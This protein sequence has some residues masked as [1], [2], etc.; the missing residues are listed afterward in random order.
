[1]QNCDVWDDF[2]VHTDTAELW[3]GTT[4]DTNTLSST[5][6][7]ECGY[8][9]ARGVWCVSERRESITWRKLR[10]INKML[11]SKQGERVTEDTVRRIRLYCYN[12]IVVHIVRNMF[13]SSQVL[14][15]E[16]R[17]LQRL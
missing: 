4:L 15:R 6:A 16:L 12:L 14:I 2:V 8:S 17:V 1:M 11:C 13:F 10:A 9:S 3:W 7:G 5:G